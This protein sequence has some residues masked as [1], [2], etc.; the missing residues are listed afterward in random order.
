ML[1]QSLPEALDALGGRQGVRRRGRGQLLRRV[2]PDLQ[3]AT[4]SS[5]SPG[6]SPT[7]SSGSTPTCEPPAVTERAPS[8]SPRCRL[9]DE[10]AGRRWTTASPLLWQAWAS[11]DAPGL[12][13]PT[14]R[15]GAARA[16][17]SARCR[18]RGPACARPRHGPTGCRREPR[19]RHAPFFGYVGSSGLES[20]V[21]AGRPRDVARRQPGRRRRPRTWW[22]SR[23]SAGSRSSS[24]TPAWAAR[25]PA[26]AWCR[27]RPR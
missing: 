5:G 26:G 14:G 3:S 23:R 8:P 13:Q 27:T 17:I 7:G 4:R 1:P 2:V 12:H 19:P 24:A 16:E 15:P 25:S 10:R 6:S 9:R 20:A 18:R 22:S 11:F 21:L